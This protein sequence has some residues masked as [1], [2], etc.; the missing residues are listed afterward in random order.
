MKDLR[1]LKPGYTT[2]TG[3][4]MIMRLFVVAGLF[5]MAFVQPAVSS[6][7]DKTEFYKGVEAFEKGWPTIGDHLPEL[8]LYKP[9]GTK[10]TPSSLRG[11]HTVLTVGCLT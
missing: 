6:Q 3:G 8:P 5:A 9:D 4:S 7:Q 10:V 1:P 11:H 2:M